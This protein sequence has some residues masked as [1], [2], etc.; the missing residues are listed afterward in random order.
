MTAERFKLPRS[1]YEELVKIVIAYASADKPAS[2]ADISK[3]TGISSTGVSDN[4]SFL[5]AVGL[6][7]GGKGKSPTPKCK[8]LGKALEHNIPD[9]I[10]KGWAFVIR[11]SDFLNKLLQAINVRRGMDESQLQTHVAYSAGEPKSDPVMTGA[12]TVVDILRQSGLIQEQDGRMTVADKSLV[13]QTEQS[14]AGERAPGGPSDRTREAEEPGEH[15]GPS[16][17]IQIQ[18]RVNATPAELDGLAE[19]VKALKR[20]LEDDHPSS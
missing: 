8:Q 11:E 6:I 1:S 18:I 5:V 12:R 7:E 4:N 16:Y 15:K 10:A 13:Q 17:T 2:L 19:K 20:S 9:E 14:P 3:I